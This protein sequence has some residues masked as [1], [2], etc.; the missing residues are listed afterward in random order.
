[1]ESWEWG[2]LHFQSNY[3]ISC[4]SCFAFKQSHTLTLT[5]LW[6]MS[7]PPHPSSSFSPSLFSPSLYLHNSSLFSPPPSSS[8]SSP[9]RSLF[10]HS[11]SS[12]SSSSSSSS[13]SSLPPYHLKLPQQTTTTVILSPTPD[14]VLCALAFKE[15][16]TPTHLHSHPFLIQG[17]PQRRGEFPQAPTL[18]TTNSTV[19][20]PSSPL[21][22]LPHTTTTYTVRCL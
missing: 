2:P 10:L 22:L 11:P 21:L 12:P 4:V 3:I 9:W 5:W 8:S 7:P 15:C 18:F 1:M 13:S 14:H 16:T 20:K 19:S 17:S 6:L